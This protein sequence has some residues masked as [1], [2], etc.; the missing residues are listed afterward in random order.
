MATRSATI[1][2]A[3]RSAMGGVP[4]PP[5]TRNVPP[6]FSKRRSSVIK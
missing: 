5:E 2:G 4:S 1:G 3:T 6:S